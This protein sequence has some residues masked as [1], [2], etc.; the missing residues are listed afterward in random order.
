MGGGWLDLVLFECCKEID[1]MVSTG[2]EVDV[3]VC[4]CVCNV[5][6]KMLKRRSHQQIFIP[7][8]PKSP[9]TFLGKF[10]WI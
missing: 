3:C 1:S 10:P 5:E 4:V 6:E 2:V 7:E 8:T 9:V